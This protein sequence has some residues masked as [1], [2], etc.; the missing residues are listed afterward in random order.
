M[1]Y[2][3]GLSKTSLGDNESSHIF[4]IIEKLAHKDAQD[5]TFVLFAAVLES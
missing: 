3:E 5:V 1:R 2:S 4:Y